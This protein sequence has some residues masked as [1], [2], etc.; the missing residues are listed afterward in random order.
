M[1]RPVLGWLAAVLA[2]LLAVAP[3]SAQTRVNVVAS[4][5][6]LGEFAR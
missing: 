3:A 2:S 5:S 4:F 6:I 1:A